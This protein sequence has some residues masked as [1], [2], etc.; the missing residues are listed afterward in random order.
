MEGSEIRETESKAGRT[1]AAPERAACGFGGGGQDGQTGGTESA[2]GQGAGAMVP[3][4][5]HL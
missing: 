5:R 3:S 2:E 1:R 4:G